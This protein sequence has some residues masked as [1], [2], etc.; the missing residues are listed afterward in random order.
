MQKCTWGRPKLLPY[1]KT[2]KKTEEEIG[3]FYYLSLE[4]SQQTCVSRQCV[5]H[6]YLSISH[7][8]FYYEY[9]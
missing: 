9:Y 1:Y 5:S 7:K 2:N 8:F 3:F 6:F 4:F